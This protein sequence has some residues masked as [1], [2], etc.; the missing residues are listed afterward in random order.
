MNP[1]KL[2]RLFPNAS[3]AF[4][5]ANA[6]QDHGPREVA[7]LESNPC[8]TPLEAAQIQITDS[9][10]FFVR[11]TSVRKRLIDIDNLCEKYHV[12][13]LR[14]SGLIFS[15]APDKTRIETT[16]RKALKG[17]MEH[18]VIEVFYE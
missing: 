5:K 1:N 3:H 8:P 9:T 17:E 12:D 6:D 7:K 13:C 14:Y 10:R 2:S 18:T 15:D 4:F 11:I 16:Q